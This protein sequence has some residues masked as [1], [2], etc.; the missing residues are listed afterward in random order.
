MNT[1]QKALTLS[2]VNN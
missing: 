1:E 2:H